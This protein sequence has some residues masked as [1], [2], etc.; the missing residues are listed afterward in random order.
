MDWPS[1]N[2]WIDGSC[3]VRRA[4][5]AGHFSATASGD[6]IRPAGQLFPVP[7]LPRSAPSLCQP[8]TVQAGACGLGSSWWHLPPTQDSCYRCCTSVFQ[9]HSVFWKSLTS[10]RWLDSSVDFRWSARNSPGSIGPRLR[11]NCRLTRVSK[12]Y[13][14]KRACFRWMHFWQDSR[15]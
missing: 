2:L 11:M 4:G 12:A 7:L 5:D 9:L 8:E 13:W 3:C 6:A 1:E 14:K 10:F 15:F